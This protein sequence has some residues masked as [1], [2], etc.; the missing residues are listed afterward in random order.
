VESET[1]RASAP[2]IPARAN[3]AREESAAAPTSND[4]RRVVEEDDVL[5]ARV[6]AGDLRSVGALYDRHAAALLAVSVRILRDRADAEDAVH[7][8]FVQMSAR[9]AQYAAERGSVVA[10]L[11]TL[12]RNLC[13]D[14]V[15]RRDRRRHLAQAAMAGEPVAIEPAALYVEGAARD[16]IHRALAALTHEQRETLQEIFFEGKSMP[17][18]AA[19]QGVPLGTIKSRVARA[20]AKLRD[21]VARAHAQESR[22][23]RG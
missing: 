1:T 11:V 3:L 8:A 14:R 23:A 5:V 13:I 7:D 6:A 16:A 15:R 17:E 12:T 21:A 19:A 18:V 4:S 10:W 20:L 2:A 22:H 9:A